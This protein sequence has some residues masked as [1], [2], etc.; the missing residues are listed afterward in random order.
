MLSFTELKAREGSCGALSILAL[1]TAFSQSAS[2]DRAVD[3]RDGVIPMSKRPEIRCYDYVNH[4]YEQVRDALSNDPAAIFQAATKAAAS[5]AKTVASELRVNVAG[6]EVGTDISI[7]VRKV[8][9]FAGEVKSPPTTRLELEWEAAKTP[10]LF[11]FMR[12]ELCI[13]RLTATETQLDFSGRYEPPLGALGSTIDAI[14]GH[15]IAEASVHRFV[16][17]VADYLRRVLAKNPV[18]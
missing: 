3:E 16:S 18:V 13:Y 11:P 17:D 5:R 12:A 1:M 2:R 7:V 4:P 6:I 8:E 10:R 9:E 15:R 14:I